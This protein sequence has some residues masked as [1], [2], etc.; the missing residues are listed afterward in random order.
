MK[1][2]DW[3]WEPEVQCPR[4]GTSIPSRYLRLYACRWRASGSCPRCHC[5]DLQGPGQLRVNLVR[6]F[7]G[8]LLPCLYVVLIAAFVFL[9]FRPG[10]RSESQEAARKQ[11]AAADKHCR[12]CAEPGC[13]ECATCVVVTTYLAGT[14]TET[15]W[16]PKHLRGPCR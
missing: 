11:R 1:V 14:R 13:Y 10:I 9:I 15:P 4:C 12:I 8:C 7:G 2:P 16:C 5:P 6:V 3:S